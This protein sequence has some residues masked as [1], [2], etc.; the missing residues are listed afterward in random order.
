MVTQ[1]LAIYGGIITSYEM[2]SNYN[3]KIP[4]DLYMYWVIHTFGILVAFPKQVNYDNFLFKKKK[5]GRV[6]IMVTTKKILSKLTKGF[7][8]K[9]L[10]INIFLRKTN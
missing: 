7:Y 9:M 8:K 6:C 10:K 2:P 5:L 1:V 4:K 3:T